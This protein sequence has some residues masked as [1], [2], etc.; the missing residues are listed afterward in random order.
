[1]WSFRDLKCPLGFGISGVHR[2]L[3]ICPRKLDLLAGWGRGGE[4]ESGG[5]CV[6]DSAPSSSW[7]R[8]SGKK[9]VPSPLPTGSLLTT[10]GA[11]P[12]LPAAL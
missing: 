4:I 8:A 11:G 3:M 2:A 7:L 6:P 5:V 1:M 12:G 9:S 10:P